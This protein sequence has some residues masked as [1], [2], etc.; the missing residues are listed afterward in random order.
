MSSSPDKIIEHID[1]NVIQKTG[2][3]RKGLAIAI[4]AGLAVSGSIAVYYNSGYR[5][6]NTEG[7]MIK[8][9]VI[10]YM[11]A[12]RRDCDFPEGL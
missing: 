9:K 8:Y 4:F 3:N 12:V 10:I 7:K 5:I 1:E 2:S 11:L 6:K